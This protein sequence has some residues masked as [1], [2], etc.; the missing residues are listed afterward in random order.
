MLMH[1]LYK[2]QYPE[3]QEVFENSVIVVPCGI[4][5]RGEPP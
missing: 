3:R 2:S 1:L 4:R 5:F